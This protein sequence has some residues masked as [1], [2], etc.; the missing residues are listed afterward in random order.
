M[1]PSSLNNINT[2]I[3]RYSSILKNEGITNAKNE[4]IWYLQ[5]L[6]LYNNK[7]FSFHPILTDSEFFKI[8]IKILNFGKKRLSHIPFQHIIGETDFYG[9]DFIVNMNVLIPR[10]ESEIFFE[11]L[12]NKKFINSLDIGTGSGN[13]AI[14][15]SLE[16]IAN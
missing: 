12:K 13:L 5:K 10:P 2:F 6:K 4:I 3:N 16:K 15:L 11:I 7:I 1:Q 8:K 14:T 9:R